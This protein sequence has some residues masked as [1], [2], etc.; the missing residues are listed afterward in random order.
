MEEP[1][2]LLQEC[3]PVSPQ[4]DRDKGCMAQHFGFRWMQAVAIPSV[5]YFLATYGGGLGGGGLGGGGAGE[6]QL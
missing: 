4:I 5:R 2:W 6:V 1:L 3:P